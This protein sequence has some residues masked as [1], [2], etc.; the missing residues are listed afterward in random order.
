MFSLSMNSS[1]LS[2]NSCKISI[3]S[4]ICFLLSRSHKT[5]YLL[6][7]PLVKGITTKI[8]FELEIFFSSSAYY[9]TRLWAQSHNVELTNYYCEVGQKLK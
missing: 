6:F 9:F 7:Y 8:K 5:A 3:F 1:I 4:S 2:L